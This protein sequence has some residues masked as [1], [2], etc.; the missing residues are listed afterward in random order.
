MERFHIVLAP[1]AFKGSMTA[2]EA[3]RAMEAGALRVG[4]LPNG[5]P[6][7]VQGVPLADGGDGTLTTLVEA[8]GGTVFRAVV[9][10]PLGRPIEARW[11]RLGGERSDTAVIEMA[12]ANGLR[13][14]KPEEYAPRVTS[15]FGT[16]EL[17]RM[18]VE[19]GCKRLLIGI[20][21]SATNDGGA[22]MVQALGGRLLDS[23]GRELG[24]GGGALHDLARIDMSGWWLP[25][26]IRVM[27]ACD[28]DNPLC[29]S[30]G[31]AAIYGPQKGATPEDVSYLNRGLEHFAEVM[32]RDLGMWVAERAGAGAA[33]GLGAG[34]M[35][36]CGADVR[37]GIALV[38][39]V[40]G[41]EEVLK[42]ADLVL[43]GEGRI[44][45]QTGRGKV[46]A[47]VARFAQKH[48]VPVIAIAGSIEAGAEEALREIGLTATFSL[49]ESPCSLK[50]AMQEAQGLM[51]RAVVR[52]LHTVGAFG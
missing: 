47:G 41:F 17:M 16:G 15:T 33:G 31:A 27:V 5:T 2:I 37:S 52:I 29:G 36:F 20:G 42:G 30:Q 32:G 39:E 48:G 11:G 4:R 43:T 45:G 19:A 18:A 14:L 7:T 13:L 22:G 35:A 3:T 12:E 25:K 23:A 51:E 9:S 34:L 10:D 49:L 24:H 6:I 50:E 8:T 40:V 28:V 21:G 38:M 1:N 26:G 44:D 46:I